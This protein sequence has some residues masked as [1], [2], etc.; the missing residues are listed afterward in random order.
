M[1]YNGLQQ[2]AQRLIA[3]NGKQAF[4]RVVTKSG[5]GWKPTGQ[6][7]KDIKIAAVESK[8]KTS[9]IDGTLIK[10]SDKLFLVSMK[11][12]GPS[13]GDLIVVGGVAYPI[14]DVKITSP[15]TIAVLY[16]VHCRL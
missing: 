4:L 15:G 2:T 9:D 14:I 7:Q 3:N 5:P 1:D 8:F 6:T 13:N 16:K 12:K 10:Q 11:G